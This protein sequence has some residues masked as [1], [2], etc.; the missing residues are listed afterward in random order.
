MIVTQQD[1]LAAIA[2]LPGPDASKTLAQSGAL[3]GVSV[4]DGT[5]FVSINVEPGRVQA[6]EPMRGRGESVIK[7]LPGV[8]A[9]YVTLTSEAEQGSAQRAQ[10]V[11]AS[12]HAKPQA[13][14]GAARIGKIVAV[15]S[16]KGGVGKSTTACNIA[17]G[18]K[19]QGLKVG[20]LDADVY[21]PSMP[22]LFGIRGKPQM[23][24][25]GVKLAPM[26][27]YGVKVM[28]IGFLVEDEAAIVWRGPMVMSAI[29]QLLE[30][31]DWGDLDVLVVDLPPGTGDAQLTLAQTVPLAGAIIVSTPQDLALIDARRGIAMFQQVHVPIVGVVENMS[32]FLCPHCGQRSDVFA[33]GGARHEAGRLGV[34]F[35]GEAPL[36][37]SIRETSDA[38]APVVATAPD[39]PQAKAYIDIAQKAWANLTAGA[40]ARPAPRIVVG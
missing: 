40:G 28:S 3:G 10:P 37:M 5:V 21:G 20:V 6:L 14:G 30:D 38:G 9:A 34:P 1:V 4:R 31:V 25:D 29:K 15:A 17:L 27:N 26:E 33:H 8:A 23:A 16:G 32:Y 39:S 36:H 24:A 2:D 22:R 12:G 13:S 11:R 35:L 7:K 18:L 19:G